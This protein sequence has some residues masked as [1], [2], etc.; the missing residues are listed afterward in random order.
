[1]RALTTLLTDIAISSVLC[2][3]LALA[4]TPASTPLPIRGDS[5][6]R[7]KPIAFGEAGQVG[8]FTVSVA[9]FDH[10]FELPSDT[11]FAT[12]PAPRER[13]VQARFHVTYSSPSQGTSSSK[14]ISFNSGVLLFNAVGRAKNIEYTEQSSCA[15]LEHG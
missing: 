9:Q 3:E 15:F 14:P 12:P 8:R 5:T 13:L 7:E 4:A 2:A 6:S 1:M 10:S 11:P